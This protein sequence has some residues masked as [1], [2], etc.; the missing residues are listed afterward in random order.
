VYTVL[1]IA[2]GDTAIRYGILAG[3]ASLGSGYSMYNQSNVAITGTHSHSGPGGWLNYLLP[4]ITNLGFD[5]Q[6]YNAI[7]DVSIP[8][9]V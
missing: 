1:D 7:V 9:P 3:L 8:D 6:S 5:E 2:M 4:Q